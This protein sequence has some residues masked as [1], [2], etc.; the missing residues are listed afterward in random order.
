MSHD[1]PPGKFQARTGWAGRL[2]R[3]IPFG[4]RAPRPGTLE[5]TLENTFITMSER[6][7]EA[8]MQV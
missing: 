8:T 5:K 1:P 7:T 4:R 3:A 6:R 2:E